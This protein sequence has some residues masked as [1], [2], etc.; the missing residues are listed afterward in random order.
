[1]TA[2]D[3]ARRSVNQRIATIHYCAIS[4]AF[5]S[6]TL[7]LVAM[8]LGTPMQIGSAMALS[9]AGWIVAHMAEQ[10]AE[11]QRDADARR[12]RRH[13]AALEA[14]DGYVRFGS[15]GRVHQRVEHVRLMSTAA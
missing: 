3:S 2:Q 5:V 9:A 8:L 10:L 1:M 11:A 13:Q 12:L 4:V 14:R 7:A 15:S 6:G